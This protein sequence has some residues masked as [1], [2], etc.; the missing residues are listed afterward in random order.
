MMSQVERLRAEGMSTRD[1]IAA[2]VQHG[3]SRN[4]AYRLAHEP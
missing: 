4:V 1:I 3:A 2:L